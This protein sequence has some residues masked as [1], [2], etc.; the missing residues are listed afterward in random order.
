MKWGG[1]KEAPTSTGTIRGGGEQF[2]LTR[3]HRS[4][5]ANPG[6]DLCRPTL[7]NGTNG[8]CVGGENG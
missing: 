2:D 4:G 7:I 1:G 6:K 8:F 3:L 5:S